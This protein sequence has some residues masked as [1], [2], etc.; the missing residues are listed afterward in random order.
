M[1]VHLRRKFRDQPRKTM[2][3]PD[4]QKALTGKRRG[5][6]W[7][8]FP[9]EGIIRGKGSPQ[10]LV[11]ERRL[12]RAGMILGRGQD[13]VEPTRAQSLFQ[14]GGG[15]FADHQAKAWVVTVQ[16]TYHTGQEIGAYRRQNPEPQAPLKNAIS[17]NR[18]V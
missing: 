9:C 18:G 13:H 8:F 10:A 2:A 1:G 6:D 17:C 11:K 7:A 5:R 4:G 15:L 12:E 14:V 3:R 16:P